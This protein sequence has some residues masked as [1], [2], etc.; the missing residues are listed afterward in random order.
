MNIDAKFLNKILANLDNW[1]SK[2]K[3][4]SGSRLQGFTW[5]PLARGLLRIFLVCISWPGIGAGDQETG[6]WLPFTECSW[7]RCNCQLRVD[8]AGSSPACLLGC[9]GLVPDTGIHFEFHC[10]HPAGVTLSQPKHSEI[11]TN[12][13]MSFLQQLLSFGH[14]LHVEKVLFILHHWCNEKKDQ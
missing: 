11:F 10:R 3:D 12:R 9:A 8:R 5:D 1:Q 6:A 2:E 14:P 7:A 4:V 13:K